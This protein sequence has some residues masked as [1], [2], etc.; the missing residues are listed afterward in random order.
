[1][2]RKTAAPITK[3]TLLAAG[4]TEY[5]ACGATGDP[6][7]VGYFQKTLA[8]GVLL[9]VSFWKFPGAR[10][11]QVNFETHASDRELSLDIG[12]RGVPKP[13]SVAELESYVAALLRRVRRPP[14][15]RATDGAR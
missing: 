12:M 1:M 2:A 7:C 13:W 14:K 6:H 5:A 9:D 4:F 8:G 3:K 11:P 15:S 10:G